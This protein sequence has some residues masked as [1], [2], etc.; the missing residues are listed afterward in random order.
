MFL[1]CHS[2][3]ARRA[4]R[5]G[6]G[7]RGRSRAEQLQQRRGGHRGHHEHAGDG[8]EHGCVGGHQRIRLAH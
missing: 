6:L 1:K 5:A 2:V 7:Q 8:R 3:F 4:V